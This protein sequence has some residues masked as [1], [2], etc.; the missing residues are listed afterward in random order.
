[1]TTTVNPSTESGFDNPE[2][3]A[4]SFDDT[5]LTFT[6][7][8]LDDRQCSW[9]HGGSLYTLVGQDRRTVTIPDTEGLH[10][11]YLD[12]ETLFSTQTFSS[13]IITDYVL[14]SAVYWDADAGASI[15]L[16]DERHTNKM[17]ALT[18][19]YNHATLGSRFESGFALGDM[20][21]GGNGSSATHAQLSVA[22]GVFWDEDIRHVVTDD[23]PQTLS[24]IAE[25]PVF[26]RL[27]ASAWRRVAA[28]VYP[29][30]T[31]GTGR[32]AYNDENG[33]DWQLAEVDST[34]YAFSH[35]V[36][37]GDLRHPVIVIMGQ[38]SYPNKP[39]AEAAAAVELRLMALGSLAG[40]TA[41]FVPIAT[42]IFLASDAYTNAVK[43]A[44]VATGTGDN[45]VD[46]R[47]QPA[48]LPV[49]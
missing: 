49:S 21:V 7:A 41:E 47:G 24:T 26:Y 2:A 37:T 39:A 17:D 16:V 48:R 25:L 3:T 1:M 28:T 4:I 20:T 45:Y 34:D 44:I 19:W 14:T 9:A 11:I 30:T 46:H 23:D 36:A 27:G 43:A 29:V 13:A 12:G 38:G 8:P 42:V 33:G 15:M 40:L 22:D 6:L 35:V 18:H 31:T 32:I 5:T 10:F